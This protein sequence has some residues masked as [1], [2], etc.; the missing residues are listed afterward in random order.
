MP[1]LC[2]GVLVSESKYVYAH[3]CRCEYI[4][5]SICIRTWCVDI[6]CLYLCLQGV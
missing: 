6:T 2:T 3:V 4:P 5:M 1:T